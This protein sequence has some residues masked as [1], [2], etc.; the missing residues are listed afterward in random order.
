MGSSCE[1]SKTPPG[2]WF[3]R[4]GGL[5]NVTPNPHQCTTPSAGSVDSCVHL[6][7]ATL[8]SQYLCPLLRKGFLSW[9][10]TW[11]RYRNPRRLSAP[12]IGAVVYAPGVIA[13]CLRLAACAGAALSAPSATRHTRDRI[14]AF[15]SIAPA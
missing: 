4:P 2:V 8:C 3:G 12:G 9:L 1:P 7:K 10:K 13:S 6:K 11:K 15:L 5:T 14:P